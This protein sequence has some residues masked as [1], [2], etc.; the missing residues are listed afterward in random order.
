MP[1]TKTQTILPGGWPKP[2]GYSNGVV[3]P[4]GRPLF[5]AG[6]VGWNEKEQLVGPGMGEQFKQALL[7]IAAVAKAAGSAIEHIGRLT[8][9][10]TDKAAYAAARKELGAAYK[11]V[12]GS[13]YPAM[14]LIEIKGLLEAGALVEIEA[15]GVV[16]DKKS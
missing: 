14:A 6:M 4:A 2:R 11:E 13:H 10:V 16:P 9:Y 1:K 8:I 15:T 7:N 3:L 12:F 5:I